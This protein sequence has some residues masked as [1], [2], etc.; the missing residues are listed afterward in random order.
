MSVI[1]Y[2]LYIITLFFS[3]LFFTPT[4]I[5]TSTSTP[6]SIQIYTPTPISTATPTPTPINTWGVKEREFVRLLEEY[7]GDELKYDANLTK[8]AKW[9]SN[10]MMMYDYWPTASFCSRRGLEMHCDSLGREWYERFAGFGW[11]NM[12]IGENLSAN[13]YSAHDVLDAWKE[14]PSHNEI[15]LYA[16]MTH[17]GVSQVEDYWVLIVGAK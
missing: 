15:L 12:W 4:L 7:R 16:E 13:I 5:P 9:M 10:D 17:I 1:Y 6:T 8:A 3:V 11:D 2:I 14:S